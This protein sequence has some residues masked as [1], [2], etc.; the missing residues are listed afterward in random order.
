ML[1]GRTLAKLL[2]ELDIQAEDIVLDL[3]CGYGYSSAVL[4]RM[5][6]AVIAVEDDADLVSDAEQR[7]AEAGAD[8]VAVTSGALTEGAAK[9][10]PYDVILLQGAV[11]NVPEALLDQL[12]ENGRIAAIFQT[13]ALGEARI[14][15]RVAGAV[16]WRMAFNASA[17]LLPGFERRQEFS[18]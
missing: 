7:L 10:G 13:G 6:E 18:L 1:D 2:D 14:G 3:G 16:S 5:S 12:K 11:E 8:N 9:H 15:V 17:P 4:A